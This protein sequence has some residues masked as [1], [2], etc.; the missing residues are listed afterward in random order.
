MNTTMLS[1]AE[2]I[3]AELQQLKSMVNSLAAR[4]ARLE[5][6]ADVKAKPPALGNTKLAKTRGEDESPA[7]SS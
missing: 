1:A 7:E 3:D 6:P 4:L 2:L 5:R